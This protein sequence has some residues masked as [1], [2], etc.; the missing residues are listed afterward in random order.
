MEEKKEEY[1]PFRHLIAGAISRFVSIACTVALD[2][3]KTRIQFHGKDPKAQGYYRGLVA[4]IISTVPS[5]AVSFFIYHHI[6]TKK[7]QNSSKKITESKS[8]ENRIFSWQTRAFIPR[9]RPIIEASLL[10]AGVLAMRNPIEI[11]RQRIQLEPTLNT[12]H[13]G[14]FEIIFQRYK[15][16]G[17]SGLFTGY[18]AY[19]LRDS[20]STPL[21]WMSYDYAKN[22]QSKFSLFTFPKK[23]QSEKIPKKNAKKLGPIN[24]MISATVATLV[25][26]TAT[27]PI[28]VI[29][30]KLQT[31]HLVQD[32]TQKYQNILKAIQSIYKE[33]GIIGF[34]KGLGSRLSG[35]LPSTI[36]SF[37]VYEAII[38]KWNEFDLK[39]ATKFQN[40][41]QT[42][43]SSPCY[44]FENIQKNIHKYIIP[45]NDIQKNIFPQNSI[46]QNT[47]LGKPLNLS[48]QTFRFFIYHQTNCSIPNNNPSQFV[49]FSKKKQEELIK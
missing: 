28:D 14:L 6:K 31:R 38:E 10:R 26:T 30:T 44:S 43:L 40:V 48:L 42:I 41:N 23:N 24:H 12:K 35:L 34:V 1:H 32:G 25:S 36:L 4:G 2:S 21:Y 22:L 9:Y 18:S 19:I 39:N 20:I 47:I 46:K 37:I 17:F 3:K 29:K 15:E 8:Q 33:N 13:M 5:S 11:A 27:I 49:D 45:K 7:S 16:A